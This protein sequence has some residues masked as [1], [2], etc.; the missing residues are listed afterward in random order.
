MKYCFFCLQGFKFRVKYI[1]TVIVFD[2]FTNLNTRR[3]KYKAF[4]K[5]R[6][7]EILLEKELYQFYV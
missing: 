4:K 7:R 5:K 2:F 3:I 1:Y 6:I